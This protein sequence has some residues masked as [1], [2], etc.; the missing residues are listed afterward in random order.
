[1]FTLWHNPKCSKS[2]ATLALLQ[3]NNITPKVRLYLED[4]P[5]VQEITEVCTLLNCKPIEITRT[6]EEFWKEENIDPKELPD[7]ELI[8]TLAQ[9]PKGIE[10]PIVVKDGKVAVVGRPP[11]NVLEIL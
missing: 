2:R 4:A 10:R 5:S 11:E 7:E 9:F 3:E 6:K 8:S 1:M